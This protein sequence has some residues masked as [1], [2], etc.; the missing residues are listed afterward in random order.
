MTCVAVKVTKLPKQA[1]VDGDA[2]TDTV[3]V[4]EEHTCMVIAFDV[5]GLFPIQG[6]SEVITQVTTALL[7]KE[8]LLKVVEFVPTFEPFTFH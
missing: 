8:L 6:I 7:V 1:V 3:G 2:L 5:A 4:N